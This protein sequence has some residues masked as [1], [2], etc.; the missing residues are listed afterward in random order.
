[1]QSAA[2]LTSSESHQQTSEQTAAR[3]MKMSKAM[4]ELRGDVTQMRREQALLRSSV[5]KMQREQ[6]SIAE[7][8]DRLFAYMPAGLFQA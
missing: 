8:F 2:P 7:K 3:T 6:A 5:E 4:D 1:M